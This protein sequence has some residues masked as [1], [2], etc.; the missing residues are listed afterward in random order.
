MFNSNILN[1]IAFNFFL[2]I[3]PSVDGTERSVQHPVLNA[4]SRSL[5]ECATVRETLYCLRVRVY[6]H[7]L[8]G[9]DTQYQRPLFL[10]PFSASWWYNYAYTIPYNLNIIFTQKP[11]RKMRSLFRKIIP[12][13]P[14]KTVKNNYTSFVVRCFVGQARFYF[15]S[16]PSRAI[17]R[18]KWESFPKRANV[19]LLNM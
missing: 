4:V 12:T 19:H 18:V 10:S 16:G 8:E 9:I 6:R 17:T 13:I 5:W 11:M 7:R 14:I 15:R 1:P 3:L 2:F